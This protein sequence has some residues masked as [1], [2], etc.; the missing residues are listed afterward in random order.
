[1]AVIKRTQVIKRPVDGVFATVIDA[2]NFALPRGFFRLLGP[3][4]ART[5]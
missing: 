3:I 5:G 4:V 2:S 1:M